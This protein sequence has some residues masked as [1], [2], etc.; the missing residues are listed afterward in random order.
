MRMETKM[1]MGTKTEM[2]MKMETIMEM[3]VTFRRW[4]WKAVAHCFNGDVECQV[5]YA[6][7]TLLGGALT[8]WNSHVRTVGHNAS[9]EMSWKDL[10]KMITKAYCPRNEIQKMEIELW[11]LTVKGTDV[12]GYTQRFQELALL[13]PRMVPDE[14]DKVERFVWGLPG[15]IQGNVTS[16][17]PTR[18][19]EAIHIA[20]SLMDQKV[21]IYAT[22]KADNKKRMENNLRDNRDQQPPYKRQNVARAYTAGPKEKKEYVGTLPLCN[23][24]KFHHNGPCTIKCANCKKVGHM[25]RDCWSPTAIAD[26][27]TLT[28]F[29]CGNQGH[30]RSECPRLKN[31]NYGNQT[32]NGKAH[33]RVYVFGGKA[34]NQDPNIVTNY[35]DA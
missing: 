9:Y 5:K 32:G 33:G 34:A 28:C 10:M 2:G 31:K 26:Q 20:N 8:W 19:Q 14:E 16:S 17:K 21:R 27:I 12:V 22:R 24:C 13:F 29:E 7:C 6:T 3:E 18:L 11:N 15:S 1:E 25:A 30:Y 35:N 23:K 4:Q